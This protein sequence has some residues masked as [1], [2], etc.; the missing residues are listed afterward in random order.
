MPDLRLALISYKSA[1]QRKLLTIRNL[2]NFSA[3]DTLCPQSTGGVH[4]VI[5]IESNKPVVILHAAL[6]VLEALA[7]LE[8]AVRSASKLLMSPSNSP[9]FRWR[10]LKSE[11]NKPCCVVTNC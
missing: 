4:K 8:A 10:F 1:N 11:H 2:V 3:N 5:N 9:P 6:T 7:I